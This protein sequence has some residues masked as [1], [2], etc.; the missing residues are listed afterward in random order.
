MWA[1][2]GRPRVVSV[3]RLLEWVYVGH[4]SLTSFL[5]PFGWPYCHLYGRDR[6]VRITW[7]TSDTCWA[8]YSTTL[9]QDSPDFLSVPLRHWSP[10]DTKAPVAW[11]C[12]TTTVPASSRSLAFHKYDQCVWT[13][14]AGHTVTPEHNPSTRESLIWISR[15]T[16]YTESCLFDII[17]QIVAK[18]T[19]GAVLDTRAQNMN[20]R[21]DMTPR[22][23]Q[24]VRQALFIYTEGILAGMPDWVFRCKKF[25]QTIEGVNFY[26]DKLSFDGQQIGFRT[27]EEVKH[28]FYNKSAPFLATPVERCYKAW[29]AIHPS[30]V[31]LL[32]TTRVRCVFGRRCAGDGLL[33]CVKLYLEYNRKIF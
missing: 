27:N 10:R 11:W 28:E 15:D 33:T 25:V 7:Q 29:A 14:P 20:L 13:C 12:L 2:L 22:S 8:S 21:P 17:Y 5:P 9:Y 26:Y 18:S 6:H 19:I 31:K 3:T 32:R 24:C 1:I 4:P 30:K 16:V 23:S